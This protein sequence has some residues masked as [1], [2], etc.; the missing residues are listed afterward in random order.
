VRSAPNSSDQKI[1]FDTSRRTSDRSPLEL[2]FNL[3]VLDGSLVRRKH[4]ATQR[5]ISLQFN[6]AG[7]LRSLHS[8]TAVRSRFASTAVIESNSRIG[9][10]DPKAY[11]DAGG[12]VQ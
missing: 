6:I 4:F 2:Q 7:N 9:E 5:T 3:S 11:R 1:S 10:Q 12:F 8:S